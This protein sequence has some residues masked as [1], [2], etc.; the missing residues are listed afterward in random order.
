MALGGLF[1]AFGAAISAIAAWWG[2]LSVAAQFA[3]TIGAG[4]AL[5]H[6]RT[7][8]ADRPEVGRSSFGVTGQLQRGAEIPQSF[9]FGR[10]LTAGSLVWAEEWQGPMQQAPNSEFTQIIEVSNLPVFAIDEVLIDGAKVLISNLLQTQEGDRLTSAIIQQD[11]QEVL[12]EKTYRDFAWIRRREGIHVTP[13]FPASFTDHPSNRPGSALNPVD[14]NF[15]GL[16]NAAAIVTARTRREGLWTGFPNWQFIVHGIAVRN[17]GTGQ[18]MPR[19][20]GN[21]NPVDM[22]HTLM[23]GLYYQN[24]WFY[25][26]QRIRR[27]QFDLTEWGAQRQKCIDADYTCAGEITVD[28]PV[29][30]AIRELLATCNGHLAESG[31]K[32][33][34]LAVEP[35]AP[36]AS[37]TDDDILISSEQAF[38]PFNDLA[39]AINGISMIYAPYDGN[40]K[41]EGAPPRTNPDLEAEDDN[42]RLITDVEVPFVTD[43][44]QAQRLMKAA[45]EEARRERRHTITVLPKWWVLEPLDTISWTSERNGYAAKEFLI[46]G[47][48]D[49]VN[50]EQV[51]NL[52]EID[53]QNYVW[54]EATDYQPIVR[55]NIGSPS[56]PATTG[57]QNFIVEGMAGRERIPRDEVDTEPQF[58]NYIFL[59][60]TFSPVIGNVESFRAEV[61][62]GTTISDEAFT[63][64]RFIAENVTYSRFDIRDRRLRLG[65]TYTVRA[66]W[67]PAGSF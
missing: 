52:I 35:D 65:Q 54:D 63:G 2:G 17:A 20:A 64:I 43:D 36:V 1:A 29:I 57:L 42:R 66:Q 37:L 51:L 59:R 46:E 3:I 14:E 67:G 45:L 60:M 62:T 53:R 5:N 33:R 13:M 40:F 55:G 18:F 30:D 10:Y 26:A 61:Y 22:I 50:G 32:F 39:S 27:E 31:G 9:I 41:L 58:R 12:S 38:T 28:V 34:I 8:L 23:R 6:L 4:L 19:M 49:Q 24:E 56:P 16:G 48:T 7:A 44:R 15:I 47:I 25:G 21:V 11:G